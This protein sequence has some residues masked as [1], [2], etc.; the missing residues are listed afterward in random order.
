MTRK[1]LFDNICNAFTPK[2]DTGYSVKKMLAAVATIT[3]LITSV[4]EVMKHPDMF[5]TVLPMWLAFIST[6]IITGAVEKNNIL[7]NT[8]TPSEP[9][10]E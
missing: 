6:L 3:I 5:L 4:V 9:A 7:K 1:E 2:D 10:K 8:P